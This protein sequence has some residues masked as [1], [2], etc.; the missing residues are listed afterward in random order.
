[1]MLCTVWRSVPPSSLF[2]WVSLSTSLMQFLGASSWPGTSWQLLQVQIFIGGKESI[3]KGKCWSH[4]CLGH[5]YPPSPPSPYHYSVSLQISLIILNWTEKSFWRWSCLVRGMKNR[6][7]F[8]FQFIMWSSSTSW[9]TS[10]HGVLL[11]V[12]WLL[13]RG[14]GYLP[15]YIRPVC[16]VAHS[17]RYVEDHKGNCFFV[18]LLYPNSFWLH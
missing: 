13:L 14:F 2:E 1:M 11:H 7:F 16:L 18:F 10:C 3:Y 15:V 12:L 6:L 5:A 4:F 9:S 17:N 8:G